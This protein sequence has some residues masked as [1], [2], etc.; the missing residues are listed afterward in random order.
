MNDTSERLTSK[1]VRTGLRQ[2]IH[3]GLA[4]EAM[5][6]LTEGTFLIALALQLGASN[7]QVGLL[8]AL[9][10][11]T[12]IFQLAAIWL[13]QRA[14][15]SLLH[16][17]VDCRRENKIDEVVRSVRSKLSPFAYEPSLR[18]SQAPLRTS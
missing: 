1:Q 15:G 14:D 16:H 18:I 4:T 8:G 7:F 9:P 17:M 5:S 13:V 3:D 2:M 6:C 11:F 10:T 12:N